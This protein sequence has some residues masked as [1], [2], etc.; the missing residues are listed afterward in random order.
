MCNGRQARLLVMREVIVA[1]MVREVIVTMMVM[2]E[3][4]QPVEDELADDKLS[5]S[6]GEIDRVIREGCPFFV[7]IERVF[8]WWEMGSLLG[9]RCFCWGGRE[10]PSGGRECPSGREGNLRREEENLC[11]EGGIFVWRE[12][13][14]CRDEGNLRLENRCPPYLRWKGI[15]EGQLGSPRPKGGMNPQR[16][17]RE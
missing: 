3:V 4:M 5:A 13:M 12:G 11:R 7:W 17:F 14:L 6:A 8:F 16:P 15:W 10:S 1:M 9:R 2:R